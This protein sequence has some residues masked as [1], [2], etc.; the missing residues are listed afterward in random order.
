M[1]R[2]RLWKGWRSNRAFTLIELLVVIAIIGILIAL[3]LPAV[4]KVREAANRMRC[5]NNLK[6]FGIALH[7]YHDVHK[8][9][10]PAAR[11]NDGW[12]P[13][14]WPNIDKGTWVVYTLPYMEQQSL[15]NQIPYITDN[16]KPLAGSNGTCTWSTGNSIGYA[17]CYGAL[18]QS[19]GYMRC[20]SDDYNPDAPVCN[21]L[22]S[23]GPSCLQQDCG[24]SPDY[25]ANCNGA[26]FSPPAGYAPTQYQNG[27]SPDPSMFQFVPG[28]TD[29]RGMF[30]TA[31]LK[32][33]M[34][35]VTDGLSNTIMAGEGKGT[36]TYAVAGWNQYGNSGTSFWGQQYIFNTAGTI[37]PINAFVDPNSAPGGTTWCTGTAGNYWNQSQTG[38]FRSNHT[39]G[40]NF[41]FGDGSVHFLGQTID[42][43]TYQLLGCRND[44]QP[45]QIP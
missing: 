22:A 35:M 10:P 29:I 44:K 39:G 30:G 34:A 2:F 24:G 3:L 21:Y 23:V 26:N 33:T 8:A 40:A 37:V 31:G 25:Q 13:S 32:I 4:Q 5:T 17:V 9:F 12:W 38:G 43:R 16:T 1:S 6:Q 27:E 19:I 28:T 45:V 15:Y 42:M 36:E 7:A 11:N 14:A 18:P 20:P 41:L